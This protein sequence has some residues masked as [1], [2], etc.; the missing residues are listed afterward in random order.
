MD[1]DKYKNDIGKVGSIQITIP[2]F[3][4][5]GNFT[6]DFSNDNAAQTNLSG[7]A[8]ASLNEKCTDGKEILGW[9]DEFNTEEEALTVYDI[10][11]TPTTVSLKTG[12]TC[13]LTVYG[14]KGGAY[15]NILIDNASCSYTSDKDTTAKA[16]KG[17]ITAGSEAGDALITV[18]YNGV[19][20]YVKVTVTGE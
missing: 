18:D 10:A 8:L 13:D 1:M 4:A 9:V 19:K 12:E 11:V 16:E 3:Q 20:D 6:M 17:K 7:T 5:D 14:I 15:A 2:K